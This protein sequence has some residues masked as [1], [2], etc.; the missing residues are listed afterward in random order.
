MKFTIEIGEAEKCRL[1]YSFNQLTGTLVIKVNQQPV[2][3]TVRWINEP[4]FA[5]HD[6]EVGEVE[7]HIIR[8][9]QERKQLFGHRNR[10]FVDNRLVRVYDGN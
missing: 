6:L 4:R 10:V 9:E 7:R 5:V 2:K 8:I 3:K 1:E